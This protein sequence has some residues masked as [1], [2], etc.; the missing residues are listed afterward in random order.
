MTFSVPDQLSV[1][2]SMSNSTLLD[3]RDIGDLLARSIS[4]KDVFRSIS[5]RVCQLVNCDGARLFL[6]DHD[7]KG[8]IES[9]DW[10][11]I[12]KLSGKPDEQSERCYSLK[13]ILVD[14]WDYEGSEIFSA[15]IPLTRG[16]EVIGVLQLFFA[17]P[18]PLDELV[19]QLEV[20][21]DAVSP[22]VL[23]SMIYERNSERATTD[24]ITELP[25]QRGFNNALEKMIAEAHGDGRPFS[26]LVIDIKDFAIINKSL[27]HHIGDSVLRR[28]ARIARINLRDMDLIA[29]SE[30]DEFLVILPTASE[31]ETHTIISRIH[32]GVAGEDLPEGLD[33]IQK[34]E[35][36]FGW[37]VFS[38][39]GDTVS[40]L[41][42]RA[43]LRK[44]KT[45]D[46]SATQNVLIF[47]TVD[48]DL[49]MD[50]A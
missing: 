35:L 7:R 46:R 41:L 23:A 9:A 6:L 10:W 5:S 30:A 45:K 39:D 32:E 3:L 8:L 14:H 25:N 40:N 22:V 50:P 34:V 42:T 15:A 44:D 12:Y 28:V 29:R 48:H 24:A 19:P 47:P 13:K 11:N 37:A 38:S 1:P 18:P 17:E 36:N 31:S 2:A 21:G 33:R 43:R 49:V 20:I 16:S 27:G 4:V 26:I